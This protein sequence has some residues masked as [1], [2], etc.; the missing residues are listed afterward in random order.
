MNVA[1]LAR[2][3]ESRAVAYG[4]AVVA[5]AVATVLKLRYADW[6]GRDV[7][8]STYL[9]AV[10][11]AAWFGGTRPGLLATALA[12]ASGA[13]FFSF[14]Y[15]SLDVESRS[16]VVRLV[17]GA[18]EGTFIS[19]L[20]GALRRAEAAAT[21]RAAELEARTAALATSTVQLQHAQRMDAVGRMASGVAHDF[22]NML[23]IVLAYADL[24]SRRLEHGDAM[25][26]DVQQLRAAGQRAAELAQQ[27]LAFSR[28]DEPHLEPIDVDVLLRDTRRMLD[29]VVDSDVS[30]SLRPDASPSLVRA[31]ALQLEQVIVNLASNARDAMPGGGTLAIETSRVDLDADRAR[32]LDVAGAG[33]YVVIAV[34]DS[35]I[36][37]DHSTKARIFEPFF[38][39]KDRDKGTGLGLSVAFGI[40]R[41]LGGTIAVESAPGAGTTFRVYLPCSVRSVATTPDDEV[42]R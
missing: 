28:R 8:V 11:L 22:N 15:N 40:V 4:I 31:N 7:P 34:R 23:T 9:A 17:L 38:T 1:T 3:R 30:L 25:R 32:D 10:M 26:E 13:Y 19:I 20:A 42:P 5:V 12:T 39:T 37:M 27:L 29:R 35:G 2:A 41:E 6:I 16:D 24:L 33:L 36:G 21:A 14:P 18:A